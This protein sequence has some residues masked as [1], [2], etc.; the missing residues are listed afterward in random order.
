MQIIPPNAVS[1]IYKI[2]HRWCTW[3]RLLSLFVTG[4]V[5]CLFIVQTEM[6]DAVARGQLGLTWQP[7]VWTLSMVYG[8]SLI[9]PVVIYCCDQWPLNKSQ[10][11]KTLFKFALMYLPFTLFFIVTTFPL[12]SVGLQ[13][14]NFNNSIDST[15][16]RLNILYENHA[17]INLEILG[18]HRTSLKTTFPV[19]HLET[20]SEHK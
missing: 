3:Q 7:W 5:A 17:E 10:F 4:A 1:D 13:Q 9:A 14:T 20:L 15:R 11:L 6:A 18:N 16:E 8:S 12:L 19:Q 2:Y